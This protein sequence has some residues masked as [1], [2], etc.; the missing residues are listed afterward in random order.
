MRGSRNFASVFLRHCNDIAMTLA[1]Q[2][3]CYAQHAILYRKNSYLHVAYGVASFFN[4][5]R[6]SDEQCPNSAHCAT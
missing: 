3:A 6:V 1:C 4:G 2:K 5:L